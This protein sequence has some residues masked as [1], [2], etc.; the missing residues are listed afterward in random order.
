MLITKLT[1]AIDSLLELQFY[2]ITCMREHVGRP[3]AV[4]K[5]NISWEIEASLNLGEVIKDGTYISLHN[6]K[7]ISLMKRWEMS[8]VKEILCFLEY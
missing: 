2:P 1:Q 8:K 6:G 3:T 7:Y 4:K 5:V